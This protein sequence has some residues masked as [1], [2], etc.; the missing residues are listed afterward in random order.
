MPS[1]FRQ[2]PNF[3]YVSRLPDAKISDYSLVKNFFKKGQLRNDIFEDLTFFEKYKIK[4]DDRP[5]NVAYELYGD[6]TLDWIILLSNNIV[7]IQT[8]WTL[9]QESFDTYLKEKYGVGLT[10]DEEIY[11]KIYNGIHH[12]ETI[13][14]KNSRGVTIIPSGLEVPFDY[15]LGQKY[16]DY[17]ED[18]EIIISNAT[19]PVTNYEYE[20]KLEDDKRNI[21]VLKSRYLNVVLDDMEEIMTYKKGATQYVSDT[22]KRAD[23]IKL[24]S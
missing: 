7:N 23:N 12:Y 18:S 8:E 17:F 5:D 15:A 20:L 13:E 10:T 22:L 21:F 16:Y 2:V 1:Y 9:S 19:V 11:Y 3:E 6:S 4:G 14:I 24:Y